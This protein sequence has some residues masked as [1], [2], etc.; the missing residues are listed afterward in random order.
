MKDKASRS[1]K[2][3]TTTISCKAYPLPQSS[4]R[5]FGGEV[6]RCKSKNAPKS[7][8]LIFLTV[9]KTDVR[10]QTSLSYPKLQGRLY[11]PKSFVVKSLDLHEDIVTNHQIPPEIVHETNGR[12]LKL[13]LEL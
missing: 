7:V 2:N 11:K 4:Q 9:Q 12:V 3:Q 8:R 6:N 10:M 13:H 5:Y 1:K